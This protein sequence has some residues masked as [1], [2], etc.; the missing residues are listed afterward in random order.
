MANRDI[1]VV[2]A[3]AGG[4][5]ALTRMLVQ[6]SPDFPASILVTVH[7]QALGKSL[8]PNVLARAT[9]LPVCFAKDGEV[10]K[11]GE[12]LVAPPDRHMIVEDRHVH[13]N[14]GPKENHSRPAINPLFRT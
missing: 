4:V 11:H 3:S 8:L 13:L 14:R 7:L 12:I 5:E 6:L 10:L 2:G 9:P 1:V